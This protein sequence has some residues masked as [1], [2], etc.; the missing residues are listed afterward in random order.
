[1]LSLCLVRSRADE[2]ISPRLIDELTSWLSAEPPWSDPPFIVLT[3]PGQTMQYSHRR[4]R[5]LSPLGNFTLIERPVRPETI[6][7]AVEPHCV[8]A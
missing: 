1:M 2:A 4:S 8:L 6:Q 3:S 5:E 7:S